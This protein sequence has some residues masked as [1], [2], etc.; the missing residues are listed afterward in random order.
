MKTRTG[1]VS[2]SSSSSFCIVG[3]AVDEDD[4]KEMFGS[5]PDKMEDQSFYDF[6]EVFANGLDFHRGIEDYGE[7]C[8]IIGREIYALKDDQTLGGFKKEIFDSL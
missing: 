8:W 6:I 5:E 3:V 1:Y 2:N 4:F 7:D